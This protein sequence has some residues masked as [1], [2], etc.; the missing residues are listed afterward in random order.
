[1][2][3][4]DLL[5]QA[6]IELVPVAGRRGQGAFP[7]VCLRT[8]QGDVPL[9]VKSWSRPPRPNEVR[10]LIADWAHRDAPILFVAETLS[11]EVRRILA[12]AGVSYATSRHLELF[13]D[14]SH[15]AFDAEDPVDPIRRLPSTET[16]SLPW[17]GRSA[18]QVLRRI[19]QRGLDQPQQLLAHAAGVSQ[20]R[21]SQVVTT[22][23][24]LGL[25]DLDNRVV[26]DLEGLLD[27][28][29]AHYPGPGGVETRWFAPDGLGAVVAALDHADRGGFRPLLSGEIAADQL[30]PYALPT[31]AL[32]YAEDVLDLAQAGLVRTPEPE[33]AVLTVIVA[34]DPTVGPPVGQQPSE[35]TVGGRTCR[36]ADGLQVLWDVNRSRSVDA[37]QQA[38][39]LRRRLLEWYR[40]EHASWGRGR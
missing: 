28:W 14:A 15:I 4:E 9:K 18:F 21:V 10:R 34:E 37:P 30:A 11:D 40:P 31:T 6:G 23:E 24:D 29:L 13:L 26:A 36:L 5:L 32:M 39:H 33:M 2:S 1:M 3:W 38:A 17:R 22:L 20:P 35:A 8:P 19:I 12:E 16:V 25:V 7:D 27:A